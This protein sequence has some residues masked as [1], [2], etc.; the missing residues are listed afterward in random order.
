MEPVEHM[1]R[2][3]LRALSAVLSLPHF[4]GGSPVDYYPFKTYLSYIM[5]YDPSEQIAR[6]YSGFLDVTSGRAA[7][8]A[9]SP[10]LL[11]LPEPAAIG[12]VPNVALHKECS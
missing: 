2:G 1:L 4:S 11:V 12:T 10:G 8:C 7:A 6:L 9:I 3:T 5:I